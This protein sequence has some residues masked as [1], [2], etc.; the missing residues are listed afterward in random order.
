MEDEDS[1]ATALILHLGALGHIMLGPAASGEEAV[2]RASQDRPDL[3]L[4]DVNLAGTLDGVE[5]AWEIRA[6]AKEAMDI[7][8][9][10]ALP[11]EFVRARVWGLNS[12]AV[13]EK[14]FDLS[15]ITDLIDSL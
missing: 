2:A 3:I 6:R 9:M 1:A 7:V 5:A 14:P 8:F 13:I 10:S 12:C 15:E 4:L 11:A